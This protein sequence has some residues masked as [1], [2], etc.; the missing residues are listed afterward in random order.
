MANVFRS[1]EVYKHPPKSLKDANVIIPVRGV[2]VTGEY[3]PP[4]YN[5][6]GVMITEINS[7]KAVV[8]SFTEKSIDT[9]D[10]VLRV[11]SF[12]ID[13]TCPDITQY[14]TAQASSGYDT[15][16]KVLGFDINTG[17]PDCLFYTQESASSGYDPVLRVISFD[18]DATLPNV[19]P[20]A[21]QTYSNTPEPTLRIT[22]I[23]TEKA[24]ISDYNI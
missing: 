14:T 19:Q 3:R 12:D 16:L 4:Y 24:I 15:V 18:I 23:Q 8:A 11:L 17:V 20:Y 2:Y 9:Y 7:N 21:K 1:K 6:N 10:S 13:T 22:T 5:D